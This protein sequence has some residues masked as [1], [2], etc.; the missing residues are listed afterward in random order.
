[1]PLVQLSRTLWQG[2]LDRLSAAL[3]GK[4]VEIE[5]TGLS[6]GAQVDAEW[7]PLI[8]ISY[9]PKNDLLAIMAQG[10]DHVVHHPQQIHVDHELD[11][12]RSIEAV[13]A[14]GNHHIVLFR[15][16]LALPA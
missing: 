16:P 11:W 14:E 4:Q 7:I 2:Y 12:V 8:G 1:M 13:D 9:D 3:L 5:V 6:L 15:T 10:V